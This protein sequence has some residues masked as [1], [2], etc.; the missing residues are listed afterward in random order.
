MP[1]SC[2]AP[3][4]VGS[5][6]SGARSIIQASARPTAASPPSRRM[7]CAT[8]PCATA[9]NPARYK[10]GQQRAGIAV[11]QVGFAPGRLRQPAHDRLDHAAGAVAAAREPHRV[12]AFVVGD[13]EKGLRARVIVAREMSVRRRSTA[14]G[15]RSRASGPGRGARPAPARARQPPATCATPARRRRSCISPCSSNRPDRVAL[16]GNACRFRRCPKAK[17]TFSAA[18]AVAA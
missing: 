9:S 18:S 11:A 15:R 5:S 1:R 3:S 2:V 6:A 17:I 14:G 13:V 8:G 12:E 4:T 16:I 10:R 7:S